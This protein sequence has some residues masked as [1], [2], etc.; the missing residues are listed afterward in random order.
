MHLYTRRQKE[1]EPPIYLATVT[2][3]SAETTTLQIV[4]FPASET[5]DTQSLMNAYRI[6]PYTDE[7]ELARRTRKEQVAIGRKLG[8][9]SLKQWASL[10]TDAL[11][12]ICA[13]LR[14]NGVNV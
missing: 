3:A 2:Q 14:E 1:G 13:I 9:L 11:D 4:G 12:D 7:A 10:P 6:E 5:W 8:E